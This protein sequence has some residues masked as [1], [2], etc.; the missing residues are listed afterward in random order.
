MTAPVT[1]WP[2]Q[3]EVTHGSVRTRLR[4][5]APRHSIAPVTARRMRRALLVYAVFWVLG[6]LPGLLGAG[7]SATAFGL[8]L[9]FPGGGFLATG[10]PWLALASLAVFVLAVA[11]WWAIGIVVLPPLV[12]LGAAGLAA[13]TTAGTGW[14]EAGLALPLAVPALLGL[15][16]LVHRV[17]HA[18]QGRAGAA[19]NERLAR[20]EFRI[21]G[22]PPL[23]APLPVAE[24]TPDDL[25]HLRY[26]LDLALQPLDKFDGFTLLDEYREAAVRYQINTLGYAL[27]MAQ[28]TRTPA[29]AGYL[30]E[31]QRNA[32]EK[33]LH[34][35]V[36]G[37]WAR[38]NAWGN[39]SLRRDPVDNRE[40]IMLTGWHGIQVGLYTALNDDRYGQPG[41]L[42][43]R[44]SADEAYPNDFHTLAA[45]IHRNMTGTDYTLFPCEP[46]WVYSIC[47]TFGVNTLATHDRLHGTGYLG[48]LRER[49]RTSYETEFVRPDGRI[50]GVRSTHLGLSWNFWSGAAVQLSTAYWL[51]PA[52]PEIAQRSWW[53]LREGS[54]RIAD[55]RLVMPKALSD[56]LDPG[57]Y[58]VG[59]DNFGLGATVM[60]AREVGDEEYASAAQRTLDQREEVEEANGAR[61]YRHSSPLTN[62]YSVLGRFGRRDGLRDLVAHDLPTGWRAGPRL[63]EA[64]YPDVLVARAVTDGAALDLV[65]RPGAGPVRTTLAVDRLRPNTGY[66]LDG[67]TT[68]AVTSDDTGRALFDVD[69][70]DRLEVRLRPA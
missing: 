21:S 14:P 18:S 62:L 32:I 4:L 37:Y 5:A 55:G 52:L 28:Y 59:R 42:T 63:A 11:V 16:Y 41:A 70:G 69:L 17:R 65:L 3:H 51:H 67:A 50:I 29:F 38:E 36:W 22:P 64:A 6:T 49:L 34:R 68:A 10:S 40:N 45:S 66:V 9:V 33:M 1:T 61:R 43:Y 20:L 2:A 60:A 12:W 44:W 31:A 27:S 24:S 25:A 46:N 56:R 30:A 26:A 58:T 23:D 19:I 53:L 54:L 57:D 7:P 35:K 47:N 13:A 39:L 15:A 48:E 8:G